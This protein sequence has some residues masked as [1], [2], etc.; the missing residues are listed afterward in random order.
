[1]RKLC[2]IVEQVHIHLVIGQL[3]LHHGTDSWSNLRRYADLGFFLGYILFIYLLIFN[4]GQLVVLPLE[5]S[6]LVEVVLELFKGV[7]HI[8]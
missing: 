1:M 4:L 2:E 7:I 3:V 8:G 6:Y 5:I